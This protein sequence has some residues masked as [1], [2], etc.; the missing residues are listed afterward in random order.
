MRCIGIPAGNRRGGRGENIPEDGTR[1]LVAW[2]V[3]Y[4]YTD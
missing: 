1:G 2:G 3:Y 4:M